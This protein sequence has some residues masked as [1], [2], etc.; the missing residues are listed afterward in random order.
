MI[1][2]LIDSLIDCLL[3]SLIDCIMSLEVFRFLENSDDSELAV[4]VQNAAQYL[5]YKPYLSMVVGPQ[6]CGKTSLLFQYA[7]NS[8]AAGRSVL[9]ICRRRKMQSCMP[10]LLKGLVPDPRVLKA[11]HIKY[12]ETDAM[13]RAFFANLHLSAQ[14]PDLLVLDHLSSFLYAE[15]ISAPRSISSPTD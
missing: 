8:A 6:R 9:F 2:C 15:R 14:L 1:A 5:R 10:L 11:I 3:D 4:V 12:L 7:Y 13:V